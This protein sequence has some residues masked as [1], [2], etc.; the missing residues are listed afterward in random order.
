MIEPKVQGEPR[1]TY[2]RWAV[3]LTGLLVGLGGLF[4]VLRRRGKTQRPSAAEL[5]VMDDDR[6]LAFLNEIGLDT[7]PTRETIAG[8]L[9]P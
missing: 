6:F 7:A 4:S 2:L 9:E 1:W 8:E 5:M 3:P